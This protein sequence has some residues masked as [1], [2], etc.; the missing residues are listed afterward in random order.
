[1]TNHPQD[2]ALIAETANQIA[3]QNTFK[4]YLSRKSENTIRTHRAGLAIFSEFLTSTGTITDPD[5]LQTNPAA[6]QGMSWGVLEAFVKWMLNA[7]YSIATVNNRLSN[8]RIYAKLAF[9]AGVIDLDEWQ[10]IKTVQGY[11]G[12]EAK[13]INE[14]RQVT[15]TGHK[16]ST[17]VRITARQAA[18]L[19]QQPDT[20]QGR[21][22]AALMCLL[23]EMGLRVGE[24]AALRVE[25]FDLA[26]GTVTFYRPKVDLT[27]THTLPPR[28]FTAVHSYC[29]QDVD[30]AGPF[31][32]GSRKGG[33]L[34]GN[35]STRAIT[36]RVGYLGAQV[37]ARGLSAHD[38]RHHWATDAARNGTDP[39]QLQEAGGWA[40]LAMP[41]RYVEA[42]AI[43]N[44]GVH[45]S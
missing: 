4:E 40:S 1:M 14:R 30:A 11:A 8:V 19:K 17:A 22:D 12:N 33:Q 7:G 16:K 42:A 32:R 44:A 25:D 34:T 27:Q 43:A 9:K 39:F 2:L 45:V 5:N 6:W 35:M 21:R 24:V 10:R 23:L 38:C 37:G 29:R 13:R 31:L 28:T 3:A 36:K 41:R 26:A 20:P 18:A 15:R